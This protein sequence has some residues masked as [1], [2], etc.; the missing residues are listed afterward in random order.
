MIG[1]D[2]PIPEEERRFRLHISF[3]TSTGMLSFREWYLMW[4]DT[5]SYLSERRTLD[6][7]RVM[8]EWMEKR[9]PIIAVSIV[10][11]EL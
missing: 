5:R 8:A 9:H 2:I 10:E 4:E 3:N 7:A 11:D 6:D 1:V